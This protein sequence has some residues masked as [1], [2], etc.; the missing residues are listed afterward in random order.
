MTIRITLPTNMGLRDWA[1]QI[2]LDLDP[3][4][5][6]GRLNNVDDWQ[7]WAVQFLNNTA[8]NENIPVP[9]SFKDWREW[10]QRFCQV[11]E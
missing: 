1:D 4:G 5:S 2:A 10:A 6:F 3:Y 9:Y 11:V 7:N 8:L